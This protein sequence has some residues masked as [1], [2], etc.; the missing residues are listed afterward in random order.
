MD[1]KRESNT[2]SKDE[3]INGIADDSNVPKPHGV[4]L[5]TILAYWSDWEHLGRQFRFV[6]LCG[7]IFW[8]LYF[9]SMAF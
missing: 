7:C 9:L 8:L 2:I 6:L 4:R 3:T 1:D 5:Y